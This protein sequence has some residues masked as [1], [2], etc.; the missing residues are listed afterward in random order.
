MP[1]HFKHNKL[2]SFVR[3]LNM[4]DF[5]K[6]RTRETF[7]EFKHEY[8]R[9]DRPEYLKYIKRKTGGEEP[10][11]TQNKTDTLIQKCKELEEKCKTFEA[12]A[13][14]SIPIKRMRL[15]DNVDSNILFDGIMSF[16]EQKN[17]DKHDET[18]LVKKATV[19]YIQ[20]LKEIKI[21]KTFAKNSYCSDGANSKTS[22]ST[23][24]GKARSLGE[25]S[26]DNETT[27]ACIIDDICPSRSEH[28][29]K[30]DLLYLSDGYFGDEDCLDNASMKS[31]DFE[32]NLLDF[33]KERLD[34]DHHFSGLDSL[35]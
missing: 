20:R 31:S 9:R 15:I 2:Q 7:K 29:G 33:N 5:H 3:Q 23:S 21:T 32:A 17:N 1:A 22:H 30:R 27:K 6:M 24:G 13:R 14:L 35:F 26:T 34:R 8:L 11:S 12:L 25:S 16:L 19:E 10:G 28:L 18:S 4:Y